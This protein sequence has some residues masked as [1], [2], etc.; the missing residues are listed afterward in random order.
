MK[1]GVRFEAGEKGAWIEMHMLK[2][3]KELGEYHLGLERQVKQEINE[4]LC[5]ELYLAGL[6]PCGF[7]SWKDF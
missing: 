4:E 1:K 5:D 7:D 2:E 3:S 6:Y